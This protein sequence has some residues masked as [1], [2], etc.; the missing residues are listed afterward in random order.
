MIPVNRPRRPVAGY[1]RIGSCR[2]A[3]PACGEGVAKAL[4]IPMSEVP[5]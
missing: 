3:D 4:G 2:K 5:G 1:R